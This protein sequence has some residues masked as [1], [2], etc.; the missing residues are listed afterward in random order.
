M[1]EMGTSGLMSVAGKRGGASA[2]ALA[3]GLD[4]T[5]PF[6]VSQNAAHESVFHRACPAVSPELGMAGLNRRRRA[7][8]TVRAIFWFVSKSISSTAPRGPWCGL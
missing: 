6:A 5:R 8:K 2:S 4:S 3:L 7:P 1:L